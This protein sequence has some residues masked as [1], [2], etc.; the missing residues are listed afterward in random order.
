MNGNINLK[1][2]CGQKEKQVLPTVK[3]SR[4]AD[5]SSYFS[6]Q[7]FNIFDFGAPGRKKGT[8]MPKFQAGR[9]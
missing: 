1:K 3:G 7:A 4:Y 9:A 6:A 8:S 2:I 5:L